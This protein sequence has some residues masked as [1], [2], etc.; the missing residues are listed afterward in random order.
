MPVSTESK[1][2]LIVHSPTADDGVTDI[3]NRNNVIGETV[4]FCEPRLIEEL[5]NKYSVT[6]R[7]DVVVVTICPLDVDPPARIRRLRQI[8]ALSSVPIVALACSPSQEMVDASY[9]AGANSVV[10]KP[11]HVE[12]LSD[13]LL[14]VAMYWLLVNHPAKGGA[15][16]N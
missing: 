7:P 11:D 6:D 5:S 10:M 2:I 1:R 15:L 14:G 4:D 8:D 16:L 3:I 12:D 9:L 13:A